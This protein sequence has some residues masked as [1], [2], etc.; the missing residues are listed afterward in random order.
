MCDWAGLSASGLSLLISKID[1][2]FSSKISTLGFFF[3][4]FKRASETS[5]L[6]LMK[7]HCLGRTKGNTQ[8]AGGGGAGGGGGRDQLFLVLVQCLT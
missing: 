6:F 3:T 5:K 7:S 1:D 4:F 2:P 8:R